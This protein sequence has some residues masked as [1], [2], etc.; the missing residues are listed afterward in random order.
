MWIV[1]ALGRVRHPRIAHLLAALVVGAGLQ[2]VIPGTAAYAAACSTTSLSITRISGAELDVDTAQGHTLTGGYAG[3]AIATSST[4]VDDLWVRVT[5]FAGGTIT[6]ASHEDGLIHLGPLTSASD[7]YAY[8]YLNASGAATG[9]THDVQLFE[10]QPGHG[11]TQLCSD[12]FTLQ[13]VETIAASANK[14]D[15][16]V[17]GP[18]PAQIG[19]LV[20]I[21]VTGQTG[22]VGQGPPTHPDGVGVFKGNPATDPAWPA[23]AYQMVD[24]S[25]T[26][27]TS[28]TYDHTLLVTGLDGTSQNYTAV[29]TFMATATTATPTAVSPVNYIASGTQTKHTDTDANAYTALAPIPSPQNSLTLAKSASPTS[30][31]ASGGRVTY[32][33]TLHNAGSVAATLDDFSDVLPTGATY[34]AG[35]TDYNGT[36]IA[37]PNVSGQTLTF[38]GVFSVPANGNRQL[39]YQADLPGTVAYY[40]NTV[41]GHVAGTQIDTTLST[42]DSSPGSASVAVGSPN[43]APNAV[44]DTSST[45]YEAPVVVNVVTNDTDAE[46]NLDATS[47]TITVQPGHGTVTN[48][49]DGTVTYTPANGYHGTDTF[50]YQVCDSG[51][52]CD[53]AVVTVTVSAQP[54]VAP[55]AVDDTAT[56]DYQTPRVIDVADN[57]T[58]AD[59]N[60]AL[61]TVTITVQP[62]HGTLVNHAD[63][64]VTYTPADGYHGTDT[65]TYQ[66]CDSGSL[67]DTATVTVTVNP[68][69]EPPVYT[70][71]TSITVPSNG[72]VPSLA[73][74]DPNGNPYSVSVVG[75]T[76]PTGLTLNSDGT[77]TGTAPTSGAF[78]FTVR[79]CDNAAPPACTD[80]A[81]TLAFGSLAYTGADHLRA[82]ALT[83]VTLL[84]VGAGLILVSRRGHGRGHRGGGGGAGPA[85]TS[86]LPGQPAH[87]RR[88][89][90]GADAAVGHPSPV[91]AGVPL[92]HQ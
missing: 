70:G 6:L 92:P 22:Q 34:V 21:T 89:R 18:S 10:G 25:T 58:D 38:T 77:W 67:C 43:T 69:N 49:N 78:T 74:T 36:N 86:R 23:N 50:T 64:T 57:D 17:A 75:G 40:A 65:F 3:Y 72:T 26:F 52:L 31:A 82:L 4:A 42:S 85:A 66:I 20:T 91:P 16:V 14:V 27:D 62:T 59:S 24:A 51:P 60:L 53:T 41:V 28:G 33:V 56:V 87:P 79:A 29:Y 76:A 80:S 19:G 73:F 1:N 83:G 11:G 8:V 63:G 55:D 68:A 44:D 88:N 71:P 90:S 54:N 35:S 5:N 81:L 13:S 32:T 9:Q 30:L 37:D 47:V 84:T 15:T 48:H 45:A 46:T 2:V 7:R 39:I 12:S 61:A